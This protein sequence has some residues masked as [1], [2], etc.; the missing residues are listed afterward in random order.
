[1]E[2]SNKSH[3]CI[4]K[5]MRHAGPH[6]PY[7]LAV[8]PLVKWR[9]NSWHFCLICSINARCGVWQRDC[10]HPEDVLA[11][12]PLS[13]PDQ[14]PE[15]LHTSAPAA[16]S[17]RAT[18]DG[19]LPDDLVG[20]Q[21]DRRQRG[22]IASHPPTGL[23]CAFSGRECILKSSGQTGYKIGSK[24]C[25]LALKFIERIWVLLCVLSPCGILISWISDLI[26]SFRASNLDNPFLNRYHD[27]G[28]AQIQ[29]LTFC[30]TLTNIKV[31]RGE[32]FK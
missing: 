32:T 29:S 11:P 28:Q 7:H 17:P 3:G 18:H 13:H 21:W 10:H 31:L 20:Q 6:H 16:Q 27:D 8:L 26:E 25:L 4:P 14:G 5:S 1:M 2:G 22:E 15:G 12:L 23:D 9:T 30:F 24:N 19:M